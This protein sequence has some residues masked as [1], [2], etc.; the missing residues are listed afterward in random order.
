MAYKAAAQDIHFSQPDINP[1]L[2]NPAYSGFFDGTGRFAITYRNQWASVTKAYQT[3]AA[4]GEYAIMRR[5]YQ[6]D[7]ISGGISIFN[8]RAGTLHYGTTAA[9]LILS[10]YKSLNRFNNSFLS[11]GLSAGYAQSGY[12]PAEAL[13]GDRSELF[14]NTSTWYP[15]F[16]V[17]AAW[18][19]HPHD[20]F[21][22]KIALSGHNLNRPEISYT[23]A[24][25]GYVERLVNLYSRIDYRFGGS[26][27]VQPL[28]ALQLQ[29]NNSEFVAGADLKCYLSEFT[30]NNLI[31]GAGMAV[32]TSDAL[33]FTLTTEWTTMLVAFTYDANISKLVAASGGVGAFEISA[34]Y[35]LAKKEL[36]KRKALPC[37]II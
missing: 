6:R 13:A 35:R 11:F 18:Y 33:L 19:Y 30:D 28:V 24:G 21:E 14:L 31:I 37:P 7:G 12:D 3:M 4:N 36:Y 34:V 25:G 1:I 27:S 15:L 5:R 9:N 26:W 32:R 17:G 8:D 16:G 23:E 10:Y 2:Y 29:R 22:I 20:F